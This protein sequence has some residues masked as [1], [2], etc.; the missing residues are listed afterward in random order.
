MSIMAAIDVTKDDLLILSAVRK[1][2]FINFGY[3]I[4]KQLDFPVRYYLPHVSMSAY[5]L[6]FLYIPIYHMFLCLFTA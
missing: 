2:K 6:M 5:R 3:I 4:K 1:F